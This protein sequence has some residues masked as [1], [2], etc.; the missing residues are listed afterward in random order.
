MTAT[1]S[2]NT[3]VYYT[4]YKGQIVPIYDGTRISCADVGGELSQTTTD[5]TKSPAAVGASSCYDVFVWNNSGTYRATRGPAWTNTTTRSAGTALTRVKGLLVNNAA[6][7]N[8][9]GQNLG[10]YVGTFCSNASST[11]D[12]ILGTAASGGGAANLMVWNEYNRV[13]TY[14]QVSDSGTS[15]TYSTGTPRECRASTTFTITIV[16]G[17]LEDAIQAELLGYVTTT[18]NVGATTYFNVG[19]DANNVIGTTSVVVTTPSASANGSH[20]SKTQGFVPQLG[21]HTFYCVEN[22]D[23]QHANSINSFNQNQIAVK[24]RM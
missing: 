5:T 1:D 21:Q 6:I 16:S 18:A 3:T 12:W 11:V 19:L 4:P 7:T 13:D 22:G 8:G 17:N 2:G 14:T 23:T 15:Y 24:F 9:P 20:A 10:T